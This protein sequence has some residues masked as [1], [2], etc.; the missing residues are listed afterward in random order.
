[1]GTAGTLARRRLCGRSLKRY[2]SWSSHLRGSDAELRGDGAL[3]PATVEEPLRLAPVASVVDRYATVDATI[4][5]VR[6]GRGELV[7]GVACRGEP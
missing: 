7:R 4:A 3:V 6:F 1:M 2:S 5:G